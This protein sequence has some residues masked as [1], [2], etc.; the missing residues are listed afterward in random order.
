MFV[1]ATLTVT[2]NT[3]FNLFNKLC[4]RFSVDARVVVCL[5]VS[6]VLFNFY[7]CF[8][9]SIYICLMFKMCLFIFYLLLCKHTDVQTNT[10]IFILIQNFMLRM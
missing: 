8:D 4:F 6:N 10:H 5:L 2:A 7:H 9:F 1:A 3:D